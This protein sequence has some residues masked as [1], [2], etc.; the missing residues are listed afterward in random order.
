MRQKL[1]ILLVA[2]MP[3]SALADSKADKVKTLMDA[4]G[5]TETWT[6]QIQ[7]VKT[8]TEKMGQQTLDQVLAQLNPNEEFKKRLANAYANYTKKLVIPWSDQKIVDVW[9]G[10]YGP[11]FTEEELDKLI[12]FHTSDLGKKDIAAKKQAMVK[13]IEDYQK[14]WQPVLT[15]ANKEYVEELKTVAAECNCKKTAPQQ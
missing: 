7:A 13:F 2:L 4:L 5:L 15:K 9:V 8:Q 10:Y 12:E 1:I 6:T 3:F 14:A 11:N